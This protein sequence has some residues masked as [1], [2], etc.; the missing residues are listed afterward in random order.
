MNKNIFVVGALAIILLLVS[1]QQG[2]EGFGLGGGGKTQAGKY[3]LDFNLFEGV[4]YLASG[5]TLQQGESFYVGVHIENYDQKSKTGEVCILDNVA[6]TYG[7]ISSQ[8][9]GE[10]KF[11][12]IQAADVVKKETSTL[13][14]KKIVD[15]ITP[16]TV[17]VYFPEDGFYSY[18]GLPASQQPWSQK[19]YVSVRYRQSS[20]ATGT[21]SIPTP[22]YEQIAL[23]QEPSPLLIAAT[24]SIHRVQDSYKVDLEIS[25]KRQQQVKI[26]SADFTEENT[27]YFAAQL[28]P[29]QLQCS[30]ANG[31]I[32]RGKVTMQNERLIKCSSVVYLSGESQQA[33]PLVIALDYGVAIEK[34]YPFAIKT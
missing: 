16:A 18:A 26:Y 13:T 24:K 4:D 32:I 15:D 22:G 34:Q 19:M 27:T 9:N 14:G 2:C 3:G 29:Q 8:D 11:F 6:D 1:A 33:Y 21:V 12:S 5:R 20:Q 31:E 17:D 28:S 10:C 7:G 23:A 25:L 30:L